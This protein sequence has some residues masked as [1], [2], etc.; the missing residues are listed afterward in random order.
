MFIILLKELIQYL[1][2]PRLCS[3]NVPTNIWE[4]LLMLWAIGFF[5]SIAIWAIT[6]K[7]ISLGMIPNP[8]DLVYSHDSTSSAYIFFGSVL[9]APVAEEALF[10]WQLRSFTFGYLF[11]S[12]AAGFILLNLVHPIVALLIASSIFL[13][14]Y[15]NHKSH[16]AKSVSIQYAYWKEFFPYQFYVTALCFAIVHIYNYDDGIE[17]FN[18]A[19]LYTLPQLIIG[20]SLGF[21]RMHYGLRYSIILHALYN[22]IPGIILVATLSR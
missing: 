7:L 16:L 8:G 13:I 17:H 21:V 10:R 22:F 14:F 1:R 3:K 18:L 2:H 4:R 19:L 20:L 5:P 6:Y 15:I 12:M 11:V 9:V